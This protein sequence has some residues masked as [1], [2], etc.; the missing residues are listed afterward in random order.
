MKDKE[1]ETSVFPKIGAPATRAL[2]AAGSSRLE[3]LTK[4]TEAEVSQLHGIGPNALDQ[5]RHSLVERGLSF[6][7]RN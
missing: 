2:E 5:L 3:Q 4:V 6:A 7:E 1:Q